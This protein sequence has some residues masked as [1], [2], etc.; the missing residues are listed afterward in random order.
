MIGCGRTLDS[1]GP[2]READGG[3]QD[4]I[5]RAFPTETENGRSGE[6]VARSNRV[7]Y[8]LR[9]RRLGKQ[10]MAP[11]IHRVRSARSARDET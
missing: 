5:Q 1:A 8:R 11:F 9:L 6:G 3:L 7:D 2:R 4:F 10:D